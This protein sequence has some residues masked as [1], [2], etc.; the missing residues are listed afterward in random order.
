MVYDPP[1][2]GSLQALFFSLSCVIPESGIQDE[3]KVSRFNEAAS[4]KAAAVITGCLVEGPWALWLASM[5]I[6]GGIYIPEGLISLGD[7]R[8]G[9]CWANS[10]V[11]E[12]L[13]SLCFI[14][15]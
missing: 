12:V 2:P 13:G 7:Q 8:Q 3:G 4:G 10:R 14:G 15:Q 11:L 5:Y 9:W 6:W 1:W